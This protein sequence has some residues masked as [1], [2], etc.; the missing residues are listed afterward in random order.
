MNY[1]RTNI[2]ERE[3]FYDGEVILK[4]HIEYPSIIGNMYEIGIMNFNYYNKVLALNMKNKAENELYKEAVETYKYNKEN[5]YPIMVYEIY[6]KFYVTL[7]RYN[8]VSLYIDEYIFTGGAHGNTIRTSQNWN[9]IQG[10][11]IQLASLFPNNPYFMLD[12]LK[13]INLQ[14]SKEP[15][16]YFENSCNLVLDTFNPNSF[17]LTPSNIVIYFQQYDIAPYSSGIR[18]FDINTR[19]DTRN[20]V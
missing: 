9:L 6:R 19:Y 17:Y 16:I 11:M 7:N 13:I 8:L 5:G 4:Y 20:L 18:T 15:E 1:I 2:L 10:S 3:L 12:I 14:I